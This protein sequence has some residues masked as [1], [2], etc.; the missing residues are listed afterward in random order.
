MDY[1][2]LP[3]GSGFPVKEGEARADAWGA[4]RAMYPEAF[5]IVKPKGSRL[6]DLGIAALKSAVALP[7]QFVGLADI[8]TGGYVGKGLESLGYRPEETQ[9]Y[10]DTLYSP[11]QQ[12]ADRATQEAFEKEG[13]L[14][15][16]GTA[17]K[18]P[19][20]IVKSGIESAAPM[21]GAGVMGRGAMALK[22]VPSWLAT[23]AGEGLSQA[24]QMAEQ[25]RSEN[26]DKLLTA[27]QGMSAL[28]SGAIDAAIA[29]G[30][31]KL[32]G[33]LG[34]ADIQ[35]AIVEGKI[36]PDVG[37]ALAKKGFMTRV[38]AAGVSEGVF[39]ELP[40]SV[41]ETM[42][43]N[44]AQ[45]KPIMQGTEQ[46]GGMGML[47][48]TAMGSGVQMITPSAHP[49]PPPVPEQPSPEPTLVPTE[50]PVQQEPEVPVKQYTG[51]DLQM[52]NLFDRHKDF[53]NADY[54]PAGYAEMLE[55]Y[56]KH[57]PN[58]NKVQAAEGKRTLRA[59]IAA[60]TPRAPDTAPGLSRELGGITGEA[61]AAGS[62]DIF[63]NVGPEP[64]AQSPDVVADP[65]NP[66]HDDQGGLEL[67]HPQPSM[68][69]TPEV[70]ATTFGIVPNNK[71]T[72]K[73]HDSLIGVDL[74][75]EAG[76]LKASNVLSD[77]VER[78][79][80][81]GAKGLR[82][83]AEQKT[84]PALDAIKL[85]L[86]VIERQNS[87]RVAQE[88]ADANARRT[89]WDT[90]QEQ[91]RKAAIAAEQAALDAKQPL[92]RSAQEEAAW[93]KQQD[94]NK[95]QSQQDQAQK[96]KDEE[97]FSKQQMEMGAEGTQGNVFGGVTPYAEPAAATEEAQAAPTKNKSQGEMFTGT[98]RPTKAAVQP[99]ETQ[100][101]PQEVQQPESVQ[102][103]PSSGT[104]SRQAAET[105]PSDS[106]Q[107]ETKSQEEVG[108]LSKLISRANAKAGAPLE[109]MLDESV[110]ENGDYEPV[111]ARAT[112]AA[113]ERRLNVLEGLKLC[114]KV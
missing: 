102:T 100:N 38:A 95:L 98:G 111:D 57:F 48:G 60:N 69:L 65:Y 96:A 76:L 91:D 28:A 83:V 36:T 25:V 86:A 42:W 71:I 34:I 20:T 31:A 21:L 113:A 107:R 22:G 13:F 35:K 105:S 103:E 27:K 40:Q 56:K 47:T 30:G 92:T 29:G 5:G 23:G 82:D 4:A 26:A 19:S 37:T 78:I 89:A 16:V 46:A 10:L 61:L 52:Q 44:Y 55:N 8:P 106:V 74:N 18:N 64:T 84:V 3:D 15:G 58:D 14:S 39:Q 41:Q 75:T 81:V 9:K 49:A 24:G 17:L 104:E 87:D 63:G 45:G 12:A 93:Q 88:A 6:K 72:K 90:K 50:Q 68:K 80:D 32:A 53:V 59:L 108:P 114:L 110:N 7:E 54:T 66:V 70:I 85:K 43:Q 109:I 62:P 51:L 11:Q 79:R 33:K 73:A 1:I 112:M 99:K 2:T 67:N 101:A 77:T 97:A 94:F